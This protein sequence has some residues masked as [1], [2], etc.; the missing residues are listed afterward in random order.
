[1]R[2]SQIQTVLESEQFPNRTEQFPNSSEQFPNR[3]SEQ[4]QIRKVSEQNS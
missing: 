3:K 4:F 2:F 1:M